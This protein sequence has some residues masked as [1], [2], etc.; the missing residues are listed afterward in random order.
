M[1]TNIF[2]DST[3]SADGQALFDARESAGKVMARFE[4]FIY[5]YTRLALEGHWH[6]VDT[7]IRVD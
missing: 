2:S 1:K 7:V 5:I 6:F 4:S 3:L